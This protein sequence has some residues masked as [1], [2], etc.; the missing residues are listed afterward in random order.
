MRGLR[1]ICLFSL[2]EKSVNAGI[3]FDPELPESLL[4]SN[5]REPI[6]LVRGAVFVNIA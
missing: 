2:F 3:I 4:L 6:V 1:T 5:S